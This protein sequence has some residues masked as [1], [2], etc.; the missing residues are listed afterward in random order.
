VPLFC[1]HNRL[2]ANCTICQRE[3]AASRPASGRGNGSS[4][5]RRSARSSATPA[6]RRHGQGSRAGRLVT[7]QM[8]RAAED[9]YANPLVPGVKATADA[10][11]LATALALAAARLDFPGPHPEVAEAEDPESATWLAFLLALAGPERPELQAAIIAARPPFATGDGLDGAD[12]GS[13]LGDDAERTIAAYRGWVERHGGSQAQAIAG[14]PGWTPERRFA[15]TFDRLA[16]PG[17]GR[18]AR[19]E[20]LLTLG[21]AGVQELEADGLHVAVAHDDKTTLAAKRALNSGDAMLLERRAAAL[22]D[23]AGVPVGALDRALALWDR[24]APL[25]PLEVE[26]DGRLAG[27]RAAL[28]LG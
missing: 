27:I 22:A 10:E 28:R 8:A 14:E 23:A 1:R 24:P 15:R 11:R 12:A 18:A 9:G 16:L 21:A 2:E 3:K 20:F 13:G 17:F 19:F 7:R 4:A 6:A 5:A 25:A 26:A